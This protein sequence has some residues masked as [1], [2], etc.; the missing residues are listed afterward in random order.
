VLERSTKEVR[1]SAVIAVAA[2]LA[3]ACTGGHPTRP[4]VPTTPTNPTV[5]SISPAEAAVPYPDVSISCAPGQPNLARARGIFEVVGTGMSSQLWALVFA[6]AP[7]RASEQ[8]KIAWRMT[9]TG[10]LRLSATNLDTGQ[11]VAPF[12][13][14]DF[15]SS[16]SWH[17]PGDE[18]G[19]VWVFP[20]QGCWRITASRATG[21]GSITASVT[22]LPE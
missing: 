10:G 11:V 22:W 4:P 16:S 18:Y 6:D 20:S 15:H 2:V 7:F 5:V 1:R 19:S 12:H 14:P 21:S 9:G 13:G 3:A 17:R 8:V